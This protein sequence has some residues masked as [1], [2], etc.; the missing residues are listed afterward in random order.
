MKK[1]LQKL[2]SVLF[3]L[4]GVLAFSACSSDDDAPKSYPV[5]VNLTFADTLSFDDASHV[6][7][8]VT[9]QIGTDT[10]DLASGTLDL[11]L[12]QGTYSFSVK[13]KMKDEANAYLSGLK[14][15]VPV[16]GE[17]AV[18]VPVAK[19]L[20]STL[21]I[22]T[23]Y[24]NCITWH[25]IVAKEFFLYPSH[26]FLVVGNFYIPVALSARIILCVG[27]ICHDHLVSFIYHSRRYSL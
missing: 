24:N 4:T 14:A 11:I 7:L 16:Y 3:V 17:V 1:S 12:K 25:H 10:F 6:Q 21:I 8:F 13:G 2:F 22:K 27:D 20:E 23:I 26:D 15:N 18:E 19:V 9:S 5:K